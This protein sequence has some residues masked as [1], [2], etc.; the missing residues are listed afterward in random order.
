MDSSAQN[1]LEITHLQYADDTLIFCE[2]MTGQMLIL[3]VIF[4][5]FEAIS[6]FHINWGKSSIYPINEVARV[7][8]LARV[9]GGRVGE[10]PTICLGMPLGGK[11]KSIGIWKLTNW[12]NQYLSR[13]GRLTMANSVLDAI[14]AYMMFVFPAPPD[15]VIQ[16]IDA[17]RRNF[18]WRGNED[19]KKFHL[20]KWEEVIKNKKRGTGD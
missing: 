19:K 11:S 1:D 17:L 5:I 16:R 13:G 4:I 2:A 8:S 12:K 7:E 6:D 18:F 15:K 9:S 10:L 3:G 20:V 14:P